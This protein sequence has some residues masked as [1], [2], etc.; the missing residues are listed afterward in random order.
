MKIVWEHEMLVFTKVLNKLVDWDFEKFL[1]WLK[2][3]LWKLIV[4][5]REPIST[6]SYKAVWPLAPRSFSKDMYNCFDCF[7]AWALAKPSRVLL[8]MVSSKSLILFLLQI[9]MPGW[10][11]VD[12]MFTG[13]RLKDLTLMLNSL[14]DQHEVADQTPE[15][16]QTSHG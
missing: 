12:M 14:V 8:H 13:I 9:T 7:V 11:V 1:E 5:P 3:G 2:K 10:Y 16:K 15:W 6:V 4:W